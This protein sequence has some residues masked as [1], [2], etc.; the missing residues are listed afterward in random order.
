MP[1]VVADEHDSSG[2]DTELL[3]RWAETALDHEG[4]PATVDLCVTLVDDQ[5]MATFNKD[6]LGKEGPTDVLSF[7]V[8]ALVPGHVPEC[9]VDGPPLMIGDVVIAPDYVRRQ[10]VELKTAIFDELALM[11]THG[12]LH[13]LGYDHQTDD[14]AEM[15][16][17]KERAI[18]NSQGRKR[19]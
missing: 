16:E 2:V 15:M 3:R 4:Y 14:D 10:A 1:V 11:V 5:R 12:V 8:E 7:P 18:L 17:Q 6:A 19:R 13:L 9:P